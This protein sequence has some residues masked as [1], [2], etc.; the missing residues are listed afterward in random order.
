MEPT[1]QSDVLDRLEADSSLS[2]PVR[3]LV[4]AA[5]NEDLSLHPKEL[6]AKLRAA[7]K[8]VFTEDAIKGYFETMGEE[9]SSQAKKQW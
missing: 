7:L 8:D 5:V 1:L 3:D 9:L 6:A 4:L 2:D